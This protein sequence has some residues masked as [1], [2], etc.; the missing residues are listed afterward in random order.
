MKKRE[1][2]GEGYIYGTPFGDLG[3]DNKLSKSER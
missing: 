2:S 3:M 1:T